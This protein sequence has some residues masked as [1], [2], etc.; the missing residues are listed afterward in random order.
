MLG[1]PDQDFLQPSWRG[2]SQPLAMA[3][4]AHPF[5][6]NNCPHSPAPATSCCVQAS[7]YSGPL[8]LVILLFELPDSLF[9]DV[10][11]MFLDY[12]SGL[13]RSPT[14]ARCS[15]PAKMKASVNPSGMSPVSCCLSSL[16]RNGL[17]FQES[18]A[19]VR[20]PRG[21]QICLCQ[22]PWRLMEM[23]QDPA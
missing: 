15:C 10:T 12:S 13:K 2:D 5:G 11:S 20:G 19:A 18:A 21:S 3:T 23:A 14:P 4:P 7:L 1:P 6:W 9:K 16:C 17:K 8:P 22:R